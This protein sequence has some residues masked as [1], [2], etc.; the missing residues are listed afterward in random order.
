MKLINFNHSV[1]D[2]YKFF[3]V[4]DTWYQSRAHI[5]SG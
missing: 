5:F 2:Y 3:L 4:I 1:L